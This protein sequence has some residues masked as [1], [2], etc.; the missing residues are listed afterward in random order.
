MKNNENNNGNMNLANLGMNIAAGINVG[1]TIGDQ[2]SK[3]IISEDKY[4]TECGG[5][6]NGNE[7]FCPSCGA[8]VLNV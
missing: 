4:C 3:V 8:K 7:S 6:L 1:K 5:K 2:M